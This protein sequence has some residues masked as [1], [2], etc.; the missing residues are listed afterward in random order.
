L[1]PSLFDP[2]CGLAVV[3]SSVSDVDAPL[4]DLAVVEPGSIVGA[5]IV[6]LVSLWEPV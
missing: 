2:F 3:E 4:L 1:G 5:V 6:A